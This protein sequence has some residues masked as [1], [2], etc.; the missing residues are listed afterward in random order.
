MHQYFKNALIKR[1]HGFITLVLIFSL[2]TDTQIIMNA[3]ATIN[4]TAQQITQAHPIGTPPLRSRWF[5]VAT[6]RRFLLSDTFSLQIETT[7]KY[8]PRI[9]VAFRR[10]F[11]VQ[12]QPLFN[13]E[14]TSYL[15]VDFW[16]ILGLISNWNNVEMQTW[17]PRLHFDVDSICKFNAFI[18]AV[19]TSTLKP[20]HNVIFVRVGGAEDPG[21]HGP[22]PPPQHA[23]KWRYNNVDPY[24]SLAPTCPPPKAVS[25]VASCS[26]YARK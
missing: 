25:N 18:N 24:K 13:A 4:V 6:R 16:S 8:G 21:H 7:S 2:C 10:R 23:H 19:S 17:N 22:L 14:S 5:H 26:V 9:H 15:D 12:I 1:Q 20:C 3:I 11:K